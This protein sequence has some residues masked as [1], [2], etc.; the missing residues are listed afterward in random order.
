MKYFALLMLLFSGPVLGLLTRVRDRNVAVADATA[1]YA[2][3]DARRAAKGFTDALVA[4]NAKTPDPRLVLNLAHSQVRGGQQQAAYSTYGRLLV[5][6]PTTLGSVARQQ[7]AVLL[8]QRGELAQALGLLRQALLLN[9]RNSGARADYEVLSDYLAHRPNSPQI[10]APP[11]ASAPDKPNP[12]PEQHSAEKNKPA[13]KAGEDRQG[14]VNDNATSPP[15]PTTPP[16]R[17]PDAKGQPDNQRPQASSGNAANG[18]RKPG[19]GTS[20]PVAT[21][22]TPGTQRGLDPASAS[23]AATPNVRSSRP[24]TDAATPADVQLQTQRERLQ[25]MNLSPAQARQLLETLRAQEQQYL[26][27]ITRPAAQKPDPS[28]PTW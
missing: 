25:A 4:Q 12:S 1:A 5:G 28:K 7:M 26:Q 3:D 13:E 8:A 23:S 2:R 6:S 19:A 14:S 20:Q 17:R 24:G 21:G 22:T 10:T 18:G 15:S 27:Q 9:P 16:E 11:K